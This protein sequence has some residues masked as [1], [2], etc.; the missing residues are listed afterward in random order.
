MAQ[1]ASSNEQ[2]VWL[3]DGVQ[4]SQLQEHAHTG[5]LQGWTVTSVQQVS[6]W[7]LNK[8]SCFQVITA[9]QHNPHARWV[10]LSTAG[11]TVVPFNRFS[12]LLPGE[13]WTGLPPSHRPSPYLAHCILISQPHGRKM[14]ERAGVTEGTHRQ[15]KRST[16]NTGDLEKENR[17][18]FSFY[19]VTSLEPYHSARTILVT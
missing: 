12:S 8:R 1:D 18:E 14:R 3:Q 6:N 7:L 4:G 13:E 17:T 10:W 15:E 16:S 9:P 11:S 19:H 5:M 2:S